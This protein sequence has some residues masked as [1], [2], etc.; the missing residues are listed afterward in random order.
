L[1]VWVVRPS[2]GR[3]VGTHASKVD[4]GQA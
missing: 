3:E 2:A 4:T 1:R